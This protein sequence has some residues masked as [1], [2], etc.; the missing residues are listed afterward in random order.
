MMKFI[1]C[2]PLVHVSP[3]GLLCI[4]KKII[5]RFYFLNHV[6]CIPSMYSSICLSSLSLMVIYTPCLQFWQC[7]VISFI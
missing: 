1:K 3:T 2:S 5:I 7:L 6:F 4:T